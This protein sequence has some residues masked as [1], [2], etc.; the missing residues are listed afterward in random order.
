MNNFFNAD[1]RVGD[2]CYI[3]FNTNAINYIE[4]G[5]VEEATVERI[6]K[7]LTLKYDKNDNIPEQE[8]K[9]TYEVS[10]ALNWTTM[11]SDR[12]FGVEHKQEAYAL[13]KKIVKERLESLKETE[14]KLIACLDGLNREVN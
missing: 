5:N 12:V 9:D 13:A 2:K 8:G 14:Q 11:P 4:D 6:T 3:V 1:L 10:F 7:V